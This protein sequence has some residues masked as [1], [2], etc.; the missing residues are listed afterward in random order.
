MKSILVNVNKCIHITNSSPSINKL[1]NVGHSNDTS[2]H[3]S[4]DS[5]TAAVNLLA[6]L[7]I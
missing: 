7:K 4:I 3:T 2:D 1:P 5:T 6:S